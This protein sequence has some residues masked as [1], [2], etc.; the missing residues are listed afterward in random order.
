[1][2]VDIFNSWSLNHIHKAEIMIKGMFVFWALCAS[3][4]VVSTFTYADDEFAYP[5]SLDSFLGKTSYRFYLISSPLFQVFLQY[6][7]SV[8][9]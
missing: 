9:G 3:L 6:Y 2:A 7:Y 5:H 8:C 4:L 1:M